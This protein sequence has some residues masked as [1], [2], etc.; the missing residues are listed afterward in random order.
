[1]FIQRKAGRPTKD[2]FEWQKCHSDTRD[3]KYTLLHE[4]HIHEITYMYR[5]VHTRSKG[6]N[7]GKVCSVN[8]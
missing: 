2:N 1:M 7:V 4:Y 3:W 8:S 6:H 5:N